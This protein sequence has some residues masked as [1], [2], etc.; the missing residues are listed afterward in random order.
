MPDNKD[1]LGAPKIVD[2]DVPTGF[3]LIPI[4]GAREH[5]PAFVPDDLLRIRKAD[6]LEAI[7]HF[8]REDRSVPDVSDLQ[9][10]HERKSLRPVRARVAGDRCVGVACGASTSA[11][12]NPR[13]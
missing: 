6:P 1:E 5:R 10:R 11:V 8:P 13:W 9:T 4:L 7:E 12:V 2:P 3:M